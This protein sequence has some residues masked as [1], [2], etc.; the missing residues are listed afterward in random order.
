MRP[1]VESFLPSFL[2]LFDGEVKFDNPLFFLIWKNH[3]GFVIPC[4]YKNIVI[5]SVLQ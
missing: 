1:L 3:L 2:F 5:V 4:N